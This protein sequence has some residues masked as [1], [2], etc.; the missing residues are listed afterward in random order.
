ME[1]NGTIVIA[2][3]VETV[4][5]Y[6]FNVKNDVNW[7]YGVSG[8]RLDSGETLEVGTVG[9]TAAGNQEVDWRI[10]SFTAGESVDWEFLNGPFKGRGGYRLVAVA[11]GTKFTLVADVEPTGFYKLLG[12]LFRR[13]GQRRNQADVEKLRDILEETPKQG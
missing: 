13:M 6:V 12:P 10:V 9:H 2:R 1:M 4:A 5:A 3:P 8:S 7:R 11:G